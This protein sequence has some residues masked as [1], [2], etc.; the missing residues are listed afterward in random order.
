MNK[1]I[2]VFGGAVILLAGILGAWWFLPSTIEQQ[3]EPNP[4]AAE[5]L[6][7]PV[8]PVP[9]R[10]ATG[11]DYEQC[12]QMIDAD[13][14]GANDFA[15]AWLATGGGE[16]ATHCRALAQ[17]SLGD[18]ETGAK[19]LDELG[20]RSKAD[21]LA[22]ASVYDQAVQAWLMADQPDRAFE[23]ATAALALSPD[24][25]DLLI[26]RSIAAATME[27]YL[28]SIDDLDRALKLDPKRFD[29]LVLRAAAWR[30]EGKLDRA[31]DDIDRAMELNPDNP[32]ALLERGI[33]R[34][35][36]G[37]GPCARTDWQRAIELDPDS[38]TADLA[39]QNLALLEAGPE[40]K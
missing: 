38:N 23:S 6:L 11:P 7:L 2:A 25:P 17:I 21:A 4:P 24:D 15:D 13:P 32:E 5:A 31:K 9:P 35:R 14:E 28:D 40:R 8:P 33:L 26:G 30:Q 16:G 18:P 29:A 27:R 36:L 10:V 22:R 37:D 3:E 19:L 39:Q 1:R 12:L 34:Q 20:K